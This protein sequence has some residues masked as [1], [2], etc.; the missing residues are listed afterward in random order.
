MHC[1]SFAVSSS[2]IKSVSIDINILFYLSS[3]RNYWLSDTMVGSCAGTPYVYLNRWETHPMKHVK[4]MCQSY[5]IILGIYLT[6][7]MEPRLIRKENDRHLVYLFPQI[8]FETNCKNHV[9]YN[10]CNMD[11]QWKC[12][13]VAWK[14]DKWFHKCNQFCD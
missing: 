9:S 4:I 6:H 13:W 10:P 14:S 3:I 2:A 11:T 8:D 5:S 7:Q 12:V 1:S